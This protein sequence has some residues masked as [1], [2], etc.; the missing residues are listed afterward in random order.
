MV[1]LEQ[2]KKQALNTFLIENSA[3]KS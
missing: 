1:Q 2:V 3:S